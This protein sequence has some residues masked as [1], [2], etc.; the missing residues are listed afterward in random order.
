MLAWDPN[1]SQE[2]EEHRH[3][4]AATV[5]PTADIDLG[6]SPIPR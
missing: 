5:L 4:I 1:E 3:P 6:P 2:D